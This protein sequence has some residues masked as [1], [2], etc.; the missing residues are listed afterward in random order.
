M[1]SYYGPY[2][3]PDMS[4]RNIG[5]SSCEGDSE[6]ASIRPRETLSHGVPLN[7]M[8]CKEAAARFHVSDPST[9]LQL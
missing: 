2:K 8:V 7:I 3:S 4:S 1:G 5:S 6:A 9:F